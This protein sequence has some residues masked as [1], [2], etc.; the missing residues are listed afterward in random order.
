MNAP[1]SSFRPIIALVRQAQR[2]ASAAGIRNI[3]QPG[4]IKEMIIAEVLGHQLIHTKHDSDAC[5]ANDVTVKYEYLSCAE[6]GSGQLDRMFKEPLEKRRES[7]RRIGRNAAIFLAVFRK[8]DP[9]HVL[10]M[11]VIDPDVL[12]TEAH[13][14]L[15]RSRNVISH[16]RFSEAWART[17]GRIVYD[18]H[19][20]ERR[21]AQSFRS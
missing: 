10:R 9:L 13:R 8:D 14:Q 4:L 21:G 11:Y 18:A 7:L 19:T 15:D 1:V 3:L 12:M 20:S 5:D 16:V 17:H 6:G 2:L